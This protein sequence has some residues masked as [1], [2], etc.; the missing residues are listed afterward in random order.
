ML[1][2]QLPPF[3]VMLKPRGAICNLDCAYCYYLSKEDLY[4][5][6]SFR[7]TDRTLEE[8]TRQYIQA[9]PLPEVV[10]G[11]QGGEPTLMGLDFFR[12]AVELQR[13]SAPPGM[14]VYNTLQ[15]NGVPLDEEWCGFFRQHQ[16]LVGLSLD[17]PAHLHD[18]YRVDK[19]G[20]PSHPAVMKGLALLKSH[21]VEFNI[22]T[23]VHAANADHPLEVY[24]FLRDEVET[25][26][27]QF[28]PIVQRENET[29]YQEGDRVS[30][31]SVTGQQYGGFLKAVFDEWVCRDVGR[32]YVQIFDVTL[33]NWVGQPGGL[34][35]FDETCGRALALEH[36]GDLY[37]CD[38]YVEPKYRLGNIRGKSLPALVTSEA[39]R[40]FGE[41]KRA[42]LPRFCRECEVRRLC[43]GGCPKNRVLRTP[44]GE[45]GLNYL[46]EGYKA[47]FTH[48]GPAMEWME[49]ALHRREP[50][51]GI[52][53]EFGP[54]Q[55]GGG[56]S[57]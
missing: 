50:P 51:A 20:K 41:A 46:C 1:G 17:G 9:Q 49:A 33:A 27:V 56:G 45:E 18:P 30:G 16:F 5:G 38:H 29:G 21:G 28:I 19:G 11:W 7:M 35:I 34:C 26:F 15:T 55:Y 48:V 8:F 52:M 54:E 4:P 2:S 12:R 44:D 22:L 37:A 40:T 6:S 3:H 36:N 42:S 25:T 32:I 10:F 43:N 39:Q 47:F 23:T 14:K 24:R 57:A 53:E 13:Q 31:R